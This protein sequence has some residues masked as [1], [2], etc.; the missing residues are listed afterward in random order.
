MKTL[1][2]RLPRRNS[3]APPAWLFILFLLGI[4]LLLADAL[5]PL[6][7]DLKP[8]SPRTP[9]FGVSEFYLA[10]LTPV[11]GAASSA[12]GTATL[13]L[14]P[15]GQ[16]AVVTLGVNNVTTPITG[17]QIRGPA[18]PGQT[19]GVLLDLSATLPQ[20]GGAYYWSLGAAGAGTVDAIK[21]GRVYVAVQSTQYPGGE[22]RGQFTRVLGSSAFTPPP[23]PP[24]LPGGLPTASDA[25]RFLTQATL[26]PTA[27]EIQR[28][29]SIGFDAWLNEQFNTPTTP[30]LPYVDAA[31]AALPAGTKPPTSL[32]LEAWWKN[33][34]TAPDQLSQRVAFALSEIFV[35]STNSAGLTQEPVGLSVYLDL[36]ASDAFVNFRQLIEDVTLNPAMGQFLDMVHNDKPNPAKGTEPNENY[37]REVLQLFSVGLYRLNPDGTLSLD[38]QGLP[39]S[40]YDQDVVEGFSHVFT[41]WYWAQ[42]G[43]QNPTWNY[44]APN[45]R[46]PMVAVSSHHDTTTAKE[47]LNNVVLPPGQTQAQDLAAAMDSI[48]NHPNVGPFIARRLIQR[49]VTSNPSPAYVYRVAQAFANNGAGVRGDMRA[50]IRAIL[51]DYEARSTTVAAGTF[52]GH[53]REPIVRLANVYRAFNA[54]AA[55]GKFAV[56]NQTSNFGQTPL[57]SPSVFN[58]FAPDYAPAGPIAEAGLVAPEFEITTTSQTISSTNKMRSVVFQQPSQANPDVL[59]LDLSAPAALAADPAAL[60]DSL[61][62]LLMCGEMSSATRNEV[63]SAVTKIPAANTLERAETAV[64]LLVTSPEFVVEK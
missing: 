54:R 64:Y 42:P 1:V 34:I 9:A 15:D 27:A 3:C 33:A 20:E 32:M 53:E 8:V 12:T 43:V 5:V 45:Y 63:V 46:Y 50:V 35:V 17:K 41:G 26:G 38:S 4:A 36:L 16:Y 29:Q 22:L 6:R 19:G 51:L 55:S 49:L 39:V 13:R 28:V 47:L 21:T 30:E 48:Y 11:S 31:I 18:D 10:A 37:G 40:T 56:G 57:Y 14:S 2:C 7:A 60:V 24:A 25:A 58:F 52:Y 59:V 44:V 61:N 62:T 23:P